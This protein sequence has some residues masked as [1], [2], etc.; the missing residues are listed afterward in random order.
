MSII[1]YDYDKAQALSKQVR[2][3]SSEIKSTL[4][5]F[6]SKNIDQ[7]SSWWTGPDQEAFVRKYVETNTQIEKL[8]NDFERFY[9]TLITKIS[10]SKDE[11]TRSIARN[12]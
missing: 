11:H 8:F 10:N 6:K 3:L 2:N 4:K 7:T 12:I 5:S 9:D 1:K